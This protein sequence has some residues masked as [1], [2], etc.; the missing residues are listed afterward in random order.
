MPGAV[1]CAA[2]ETGFVVELRL[3]DD[4]LTVAQV[5][6][7]EVG[8]GTIRL[9]GELKAADVVVDGIGVVVPDA[10]ELVCGPPS[11]PVTR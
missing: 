3:G 2:V 6:D 11:V 9:L 4:E 7:P 10:A 1:A 5:G 8:D